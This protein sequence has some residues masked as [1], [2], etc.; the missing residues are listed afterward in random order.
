MNMRVTGSFIAKVAGIAGIIGLVV[1]HFWW[2]RPEAPAARAL[3]VQQQWEL[4]IGQRVADYRIVGGLGDISIALQGGKVQAPFGGEVRPHM[5]DCVIFSSPG[6]PAYL[7]RLCGLHRPQL[8]AVKQGETIGA[9]EMLQFATLRKQPD[10][11]W[12]LVEPSRDLLERSL[13]R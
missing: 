8:G 1:G 9:G 7:F 12:S 6:V 5:P 2:K 13:R 4:E 11:S 3:Q 10:G